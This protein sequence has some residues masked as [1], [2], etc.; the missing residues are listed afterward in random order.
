MSIAKPEQLLIADDDPNLLAAYVLFFEAHGYE[1]Q[2]AG[3]GVDA[4]AQYRAWH[5]EIV[6]LDIQMPRVDGRTVATEI[7]KLKIKE[8]PLL[9]AVS[10]LSEPSDITE[11][12][13]S[14]FDQ[15]FVKPAQLPAILAVM[16]SRPRAPL[17]G[18]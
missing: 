6:I 4:L 18:P 2:T 9:V 14:G 5:P 15:H 17:R 12:I 16:L 13:K 11:S 3:D 10:A 1:I 7:R 8:V